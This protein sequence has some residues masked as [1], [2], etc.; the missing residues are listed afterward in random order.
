MIDEYTLWICVH[1]CMHLN[2][3]LHR[4]RPS[5]PLVYTTN[6]TKVA[7]AYNGM[8]TECKSTIQQ[9]SWIHRND[10]K[11]EYFFDPTNSAFFQVTSQTVFERKLLENVTFQI[12]FAGATFE[13]QAQV[14]NTMH[15]TEDEKRLQ[16]LA[17][18]FGRIQNT[19]SLAWKVKEKRLEDGSLA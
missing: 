19:D 15:G 13:S 7:A 3:Y 10:V 2:L 5:F 9:S 17:K 12:T 16:A 18:T 6:G 8:C 1:A 11:R 14:Y 4:N